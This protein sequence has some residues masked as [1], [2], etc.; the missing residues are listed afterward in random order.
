[1]ESELKRQELEL[2]GPPPLKRRVLDKLIIHVPSQPQQYYYIKNG[3]FVLSLAGNVNRPDQLL[4][5]TPIVMKEKLRDKLG[6]GS[7]MWYLEDAGDGFCYIVSML[8]GFVL[9]IKGAQ[10]TTSTPII[11]WPKNSPPTVIANQKWKIDVEEGVITS[12]LNGQV[13]GVTKRETS[14]SSVV[15]MTKIGIAEEAMSQRWEFEPI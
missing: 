5:G 11:L 2:N 7:Q 12:Q 4:A 13:L 8:N 6:A 15:M 1:M 3:S 14:E 10:W 9:D